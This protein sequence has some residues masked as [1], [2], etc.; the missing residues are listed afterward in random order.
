VHGA[1]RLASNSLLEGLVFA[2]RIAESITSTVDTDAPMPEPVVESDPGDV[3]DAG[4]RSRLQQAMTRGAGVL[5]SDESLTATAAVLGELGHTRATPQV[6]AW[7][8]T[9]LLTVASA[10]VAAAL[11]RK[12]TRGCHWREDFPEVRDEWRGHLLPS[13]ASGGALIESWEPL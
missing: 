8:A 12:E 7:E 4:I 9:N 3:V 13:I 2:R 1:N 5:R 6:A 10:L 11:R